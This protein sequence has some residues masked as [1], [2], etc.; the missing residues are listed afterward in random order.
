M[1]ILEEEDCFVLDRGFQDAIENCENL[2]I[3]TNMPNLLK[4]NQKQFTTLQANQS[5]EVT[6]VRW[7]VEAVNGRIKKKFKFFDN[8]VPATYIP[9][10]NSL[11]RIGC[12]IINAFCPPIF[13]DSDFEDKI[14]TLAQSKF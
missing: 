6:M 5:R 2:G 7:I 11:F 14:V 9:K 10:L 13:T 8:V 4:K 1:G 3:K 12:A